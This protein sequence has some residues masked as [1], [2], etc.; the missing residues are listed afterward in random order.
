MGALMTRLLV[1]SLLL[2]GCGAD[3][4]EEREASTDA[5][6]A[7][8][9]AP[10]YAVRS[11][12]APIDLDALMSRTRHAFRSHGGELRAGH[13]DWEIRAAADGTQVTFTPRA[14]SP[15]GPA[16]R[17]GAPAVFRG[18]RSLE[19]TTVATEVTQAGELVVDRGTVRERWQNRADG[20]EVRW[21][22]AEEPAGA[23]PLR[24]RLPVTGMDLDVVDDEGLRFRDRLG[25]IAIRFGHATWVDAGGER[26]PVPCVYG[27]GAISMEVPAGVVARTR[28]PAVLDPIVYAEVA[29]LPRMGGSAPSDQLHPA[30]HAAGAQALVAWSDD[31]RWGTS[32]PGV[33]AARVSAA[34]TILDPTGLPLGQ[35]RLT[36][37]DLR[38]A[39]AHA[40]GVF[41]VAWAAYDRVL[42]VR[43]AADGTVL[44]S[45]PV[46]VW[47][48]GPV[49][50]VDVAGGGTDFLVVW[51]GTGAEA[52]VYGA[53][54]SGA[55]LVL[56]T[57]PITV[58]AASGTQGGP[59]ADFDGTDWLVVWSDQRAGTGESDVYGARVRTTGEV[60]D[61]AGLPITTAA[62]SQVEPDVAFDGSNHLVV[63]TDQA[64]P[65]IYGAQVAPAGT[66]VGSPA[67]ISRGTND[68]TPSVAWDGTEFHVAWRASG[69]GGW[70]I[71]VVT[72]PSTGP[73]LGS[74]RSVYAGHIP[75]SPSVAASPDFAMISFHDDID[76]T[77]D[78]DA[79]GLRIDTHGGYVP[80]RTAPVIVSRSAPAQTTPRV[81]S[82]GDRYLVVWAEY[83]A[84][85]L[86]DIYGARFESDGTLVDSTGFAIR[87]GTPAK[88]TPRVASNGTGWLVTW[89]DTL[90]TV[91]GTPQKD[92][93][94]QIV[95]D[96]SYPVSGSGFEIVRY[97]YAHDLAWTGSTYQVV[98]D[99][100]TYLGHVTVSDTRTVG[101]VRL[102]TGTSTASGSPVLI[103]TNARIAFYTEDLY[104]RDLEGYRFG[105]GSLFTMDAGGTYVIDPAVASGGGAHLV[106]WSDQYSSSGTWGRLL[107][108][109]LDDTGA[110]LDTAPR[111]LAG[112]D[113]DNDTPAVTFDGESFF[114][115][116]SRGGDLY[117]M[118]VPPD[119]SILDASPSPISSE[120]GVERLADVSS[121]GRGRAMVVY[122]RHVDDPD[123]R[124]HRVRARIVDLALSAGDPQG[125]A[126]ESGWACETGFCVDGVCCDTGCGYG[127]LDDCQVC[128]ASAGASADG[129]CTLVSSGTTCREGAGPC[130]LAEACD[131]TSPECPADA[132]E[133]AG[134]AC[135]DPAEGPCALDDACDGTG[136]ACVTG[137]RRPTGTTC[138][139]ATG[140]CDLA[141]ACDGVSPTCP[142]DALQP[143]SAVCRAAVSRCDREERCDGSS[144]ECPADRIEPAGHICRYAR[145]P[146][147]LAE[148]CDGAS[149]ECPS[150]L[151]RD[152]GTVCREAAGPCDRPEA[153]SRRTAACPPDERADPGTPCRPMAGSCD[154]EEV[155]DGEST[156]C[157]P[158]AV[159]PRAT[160]CRP[161]DGACDVAE[162]CDG[163]SPT[164]S[165]D[166][167]RI[168]GS[169][170]DDG[171]VC[172]GHDEC[173]AG[174]C[175][176]GEPVACTGGRSC[177][178]E[179]GTCEPPAGG[180]GCRVAGRSGAPAPSAP[181]VSIAVLL[182]AARRRSLRGRKR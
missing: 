71:Y 143:T 175:V 8:P 6:T 32:V 36:G 38:P 50:S 45:A 87:T 119:G 173:Q 64:L 55:G 109:R 68:R 120:P 65:T 54:L 148:R 96:T 90:R 163:E 82:N 66:V 106:V 29:T 10:K 61:P 78:Y 93:W 22:I 139:E 114:V 77:F 20:A 69:T 168:D 159:L 85:G 138:R 126:C 158:D 98:Y 23:G 122:G 174:A 9:E 84:D 172:N 123:L 86:T 62:G 91:S 17:F 107:S 53:R 1:L 12:S 171:R 176:S 177:V 35:G 40:A 116:S 60:R 134:V 124:V 49:G 104:D 83:G 133:P 58:S 101:S 21:E 110:A 117:G 145:G 30:A 142:A 63:W 76:A 112:N 89:I 75:S 135:G 39:V 19:P 16:L 94:G 167:H 42:A 46:V 153:C 103:S 130:D 48:G 128:S 141:E 80:W 81:A 113:R 151:Y 14:D 56:D 165:I 92:L 25:G 179:T 34:G 43:V 105:A 100:G 15:G 28:F 59:A 132:F 156:T 95:A 99:A 150:D 33:F 4:G 5:S 111:V 74:E 180:C 108:R 7:R 24:L 79:L 149:P 170:C 162:A 26:T 129:V 51:G 121:D 144:V 137:R 147:D 2:A 152:E 181:L 118:R 47:E 52:D 37:T 102:V 182:G 57:T 70:E 136:P 154:V 31:R 155:C 41:V 97:A 161:A 13:E 88:H 146:C 157:P 178:E 27:D 11:V 160:V 72:V 18:G 127:S 166:R 169:G 3:G 67:R 140:P 115:V 164:C 73:G 131:G 44:D 125:S